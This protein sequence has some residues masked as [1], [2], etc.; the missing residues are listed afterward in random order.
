[1]PYL[2][3]EEKLLKEFAE[4][5]AFV[6]ESREVIAEQAESD[7]MRKEADDQ[8][9]LNEGETDELGKSTTKAL[10]QR[11]VT[12]MLGKQRYNE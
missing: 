10:T 3:E 5:K 9:A 2:T 11:L 1:M 8:K 4:L 7:R 12:N 6:K